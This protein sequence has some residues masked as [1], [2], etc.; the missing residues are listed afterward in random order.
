MTPRATIAVFG[1]SGFYS[2]L[3]DAE[4]VVV[5]SSWG[6]PSGPVTV[7]V[8]GE[9]TVAFLPRHGPRHH[10]APHRVNYR[11][12][13][14]VMRQLGVRAVVAPFACGSLRVDYRPGDLV[15]V[16][17]FVDRTS[18]RADTFFDDFSAG[19]QHASM[20]DPYDAAMGRIIVTAG[21]QVGFTVH[22]A[23]T[24]VVVNGPRF[25]TRAESASFRSAGFDLV[26][27]T[28]YPEAALAREAGLAYAGVGL[29]TDYDSGLDGDDA[30]EPVSQQQVFAAF[31]GNV[32]R[33]RD[34]LLQVL[35][36]L[37]RESP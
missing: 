33:L 6:E 24:V 17:Q 5:E 3:D 1:G 25:S 37:A 2:L 9:V 10:L 4:E 31:E 20:A 28:Q 15:V 32:A 11:A 26:N 18:G 7:G 23:G 21:R 22:E 34:L 27:M 16:D 30:V 8:V 13:I 36:R 29:V 35:P 14:D 19:P 12:N